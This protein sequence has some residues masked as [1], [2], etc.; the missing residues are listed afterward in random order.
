[1]SWSCKRILL[2]SFDLKCKA[3]NIRV[4]YHIITFTIMIL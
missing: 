4:D 3:L 1:M 2:L